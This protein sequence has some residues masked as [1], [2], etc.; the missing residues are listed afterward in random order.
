MSLELREERWK[1]NFDKIE[2]DY[3]YLVEWW[4]KN[5]SCP[6]DSEENGIFCKHFDKIL[7]KTFGKRV[8]E[9]FNDRLHIGIETFNEVIK[10]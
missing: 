7:V 5:K 1:K 8:E 4:E 6:C 10:K 9:S 2:E 3:D